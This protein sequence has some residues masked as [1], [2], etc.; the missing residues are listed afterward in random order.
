MTATIA[1]PGG[2]GRGQTEPEHLVKFDIDAM[3]AMG[4]GLTRIHHHAQSP[5]LLDYCDEVGMLNVLTLRE[6]GFAP[7]DV[8]LF[9]FSLFECGEA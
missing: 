4:A 2:N 1:G 7:L 6:T 9:R 3:K 8:L 5:F